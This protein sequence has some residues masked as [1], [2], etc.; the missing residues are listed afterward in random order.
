MEKTISLNREL[1]WIEIA[2]C[3]AILITLGSFVRIPLYP[4]P[5]TLQT[6]AIFLLGLTQSPRQAFA[7]AV[8]Y[9][10]CA[11]MGLPVFAGKV[12]SLWILGKCGG[13][14]VAFPIAAFLIAWMR[15]KYSPLVALVSAQ[16]VIFAFGWIWLTFYFGVEVAFMK[17]VLIFL[18]S[19]GLKTMLALAT[20]RWRIR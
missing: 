3:G 12:H 7:S 14:L 18:P 2:L 6:L 5:F 11:S 17:G 13:Y 15:Q 4:V 8:C 1:Q 19:E 9:L 20:V 10:L 16:V